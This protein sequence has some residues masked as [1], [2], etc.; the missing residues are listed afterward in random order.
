LDAGGQHRHVQ[1]T[2]SGNEQRETTH[3]ANPD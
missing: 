1:H 3:E 2:G